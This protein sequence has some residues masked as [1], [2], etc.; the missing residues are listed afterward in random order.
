MGVR[1]RERE[2]ESFSPK[3]L[4]PIAIPDLKRGIVYISPRLTF[5]TLLIITL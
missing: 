2:R 3:T 5:R 4:C 1:K